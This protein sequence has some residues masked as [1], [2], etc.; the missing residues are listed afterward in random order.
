LRQQRIANKPRYLTGKGWLTDSDKDC[1]ANGESNEVIELEGA[2][3]GDDVNKVLSA[4]KPAP[5]D[6][7]AY[8]T[9]P[10]TQDMFLAIGS[11]EGPKPTADRATATAAT[12]NEQARVVQASS[13][14]DDLD[15]FLSY[16]AEATGEILLREMSTET[17]QRIVGIGAAWPEIE[18]EEYINYIYLSIVASSSGKPNKAL[19]IANFQQLAPT[20]LAAG[21][22]PQ[23]LV[24]EALRRLDDRLEVDDA[25]ST[26][27]IAPLSPMQP[28]LGQT[29]QPTRQGQLPAQVRQD[30]ILQQQQHV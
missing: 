29:A 7:A 1:L 19:E 22:N 17:V 28:P 10:L 18:R 16:L 26:S 23:F 27:P 25:F 21:A 13:N 15:D 24:R 20:L 6:P 3:P 12:I 2:K 9:G 14:V 11:E 30:Q 5:I 8:D 4:W